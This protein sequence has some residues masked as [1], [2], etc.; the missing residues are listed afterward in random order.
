MRALHLRSR[1]F[2]PYKPASPAVSTARGDRLLFLSANAVSGEVPWGVLMD[3]IVPG[4]IATAAIPVAFAVCNRP[5]MKARAAGAPIGW[6]AA[7]DETQCA[8][9]FYRPRP[10]GAAAQDARQGG[11]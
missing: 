8:S 4:G 11:V 3:T 1:G 6:C 10:A 7:D 9:Y 5:P 2:C